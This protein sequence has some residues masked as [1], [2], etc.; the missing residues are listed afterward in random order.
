MIDEELEA[1]MKLVL[2]A[3][4]LGRAARNAAAIKNRQPLSRLIICGADKTVMSGELAAVLEG[5]LNVREVQFSDSAEEYMSYDVKPQL[6]TVGPKYGK[7]LGG[8]R[9]HLASHGAEAVA[10]V[11]GGG[12]YDFEVGGSP[13]SLAESD[14]LVAAAAGGDT[15]RVGR[16]ADRGARLRDNARSQRGRV[17]ARTRQQG[18]DDEKGERF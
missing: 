4:N 11:R 7:L 17:C 3:A 15:R 18:A 10:A 5:E 13:V 8:I 16:R 12:T 1:G 14:M 6:K 2:S 9:E